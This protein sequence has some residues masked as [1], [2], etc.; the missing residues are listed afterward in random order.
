[1]IGH[2]VIDRQ[3]VFA[4]DCA[5]QSSQMTTSLIRSTV[6]SPTVENSCTAQ[7]PFWVWLDDWINK[8]LGL[9]CV[10]ATRSGW[11][12]ECIAVRVRKLNYNRAVVV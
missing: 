8:D 6:T 2:W 10:V 12:A 1:M 4:P 5:G 9:W 3:V 7:L 11:R